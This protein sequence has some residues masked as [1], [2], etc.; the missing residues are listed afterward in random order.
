MHRAL[1]GSR[2]KEGPGV[3]TR[4]MLVGIRWGG[5]GAGAHFMQVEVG[6]SREVMGN[7]I[8]LTSV[9]VCHCDLRPLGPEG[10]TLTGSIT[11]PLPPWSTHP[12]VKRPKEL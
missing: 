12:G 9:P 5:A 10:V 3:G 1:L 2:T 7:W 11:E 6:V 8:S 4:E